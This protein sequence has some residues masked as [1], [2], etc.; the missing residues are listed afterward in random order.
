MRIK[1]NKYLS[2]AIKYINAVQL[3]IPFLFQSHCNYYIRV[4][5]LHPETIV[6][7]FATGYINNINLELS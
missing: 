3:G 1:C 5:L 4:N 7:A 2:R 6:V